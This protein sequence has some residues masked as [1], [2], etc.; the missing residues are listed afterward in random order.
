[1]KFT[2]VGDVLIQ[3]R[4]PG[5]YEG[6]QEIKSIIE[7][8]DFRFFNLETTVNS[9]EFYAS[10]FCGGS[11]LRVEP[12][13]LDDVGKMNFNVVSI[14]NNHSLDFSYGGLQNTMKEVK[15]RGWIQAGAGDNL[16]EA[17]APAYLDTLNGR[18]AFIGVTSSFY[19]PARA[20][21]QSR[22]LPGR[23][24]INGMRYDEIYEVG[25]EELGQLR[26]IAEITKINGRNEIRRKE[27]YLEESPEGYFDFKGLLFVEGDNPGRKSILDE[28]DMARIEKSI[29]EAKLQ[30][31]YIVISIHSHQVRNGDKDAPDFFIEELAHRC[32]DLGANAIIGHGPH[33]VRGIEIY[34]DAPIFYS[35]GNFVFHNENIP[36]APEEFYEKYGLSS[37]ATMNELF[38]KRSNGFTKGL[39]TQPVIFDSVI[40]Y[41]EMEDGKLTKLELYPVE[42]GYGEKRSVSGWP[43]LTKDA[44]VL[45]RIQKLS[46]PYG[47]KIELRDGIGIVL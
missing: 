9:G 33:L 11:Y 28:K 20:G 5:E 15:K 30:A 38:E 45:E 47:T 19:A 46:E 21:Y 16:S 3:K 18:I 39:Q 13:V 25:K 27:G 37:D 40:P 1:M 31:D 29:Y 34:K 2:A 7:K 43:R 32:I 36:Y 41:W 6:F 23:P 10:Q 8:G 14:C 17:S 24:G 4:L 26:H 22:R 44:R 42:L 35:L 12:E